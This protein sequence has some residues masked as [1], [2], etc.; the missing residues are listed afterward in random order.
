MHLTSIIVY[1]M[2]EAEHFGELKAKRHINLMISEAAGSV[3]GD[4]H[5]QNNKEVKGAAG[6]W[7]ADDAQ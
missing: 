2:R 4:P 1:L 5:E 7:S 6:L 3:T